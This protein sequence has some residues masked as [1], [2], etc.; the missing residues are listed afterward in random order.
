MSRFAYTA[1][2]LELQERFDTTALAAAEL[3]V[4]VHDALSPGDRALVEQAEMFWLS[5]VDEQ[6]PPHRPLQRWCAR[7]RENAR[8]QDLAVS[9]F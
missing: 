4:I 6:G 3:Q 1:Q 2:A 7:V 9:V 8:R 5:S